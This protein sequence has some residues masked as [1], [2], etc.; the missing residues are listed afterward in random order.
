MAG[1]GD[2]AQQ[3]VTAVILDFDG[4]IADTERLHLSAFQEIFAGRGWVLGEAE[5]FERYLGFDDRR[6]VLAYIADR[7]LEVP[8]VVVED[9][10]TAKAR[11]FNR[12]VSAQDTLYPGARTAVLQLAAEYTLAIASGALHHEIVAMLETGGLGGVIRVIVAADDVVA[13][14]PSPEPYL[15]A[16]SRLG[17]SPSR[18][19]AVEDSPAGLSAAKAAGM[20]AIAVTTTSPSHALVHADRIVAGLADVTPAVVTALGTPAAL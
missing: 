8:G 9:L 19:V 17:V 10:V 4:V 6:L 3:G 2:A 15:A 13:T 7:H 14:K 20:R 5:Y 18:C 12:Y 11:A 16:A 1:T